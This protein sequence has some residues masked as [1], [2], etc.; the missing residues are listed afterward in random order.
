MLG[1]RHLKI[2][3]DAHEAVG[4]V[5]LNQVGPS[6]AKTTGT[7]ALRREA[8]CRSSAEARPIRT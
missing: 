5:G 8:A 2:L 7:A 6:A 1:G 3:E 4:K